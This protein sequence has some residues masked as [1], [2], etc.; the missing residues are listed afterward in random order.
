MQ[1][2]IVKELHLYD[3]LQASVK[4]LDRESYITLLTGWTGCLVYLCNQCLRGTFVL[5]TTAF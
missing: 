3:E 5:L 2:G 4:L 1:Q